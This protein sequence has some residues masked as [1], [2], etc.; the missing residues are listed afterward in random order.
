[1]GAVQWD[2]HNNRNRFN[3]CIQT[4]KWLQTTAGEAICYTGQKKTEIGNKIY[5]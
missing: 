3:V 1:M 2:A 5:S 4:I